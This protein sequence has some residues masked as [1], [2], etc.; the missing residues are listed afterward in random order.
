[1]SVLVT[2]FNV[3]FKDCRLLIFVSYLLIFYFV[4][5]QVSRVVEMVVRDSQAVDL[6]SLCVLAGECV[7]HLSVTLTLINYDGTNLEK[8][9]Y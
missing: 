6:E 4:A 7:W 2:K 8:F 5:L 1:M 9:N 3:F